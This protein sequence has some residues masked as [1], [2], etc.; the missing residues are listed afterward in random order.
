MRWIK[1][2]TINIV[3]LLFLLLFLE[4]LSAFIRLSS[5][6]NIKLPNFT[7][8]N[9]VVDFN[10]PYH[11]C[12]EMKT[13]VLLSHV[14]NTRNS[15]SP[16]KGKVINDYVSYGI[17]TKYEN[18]IL[19]LGGST[20][21]G[22]YQNISNGET[23]PKILSEYSKDKF[24]IL[25]GGVGAYS[26]L[27]ELY[28]FVRDG[29][30]INNLRYVIS[31]NGINELPDYQGQEI[32]RS[33]NY[34]FLSNY[35]VAMNES[36]VWID[37]RIS[38]TGKNFEIYVRNFLPN[39]MSLIDYLLIGSRSTNEKVSNLV[40]QAEGV[41]QNKTFKTIN[42][43]ERWESNVKRLNA[44]VKASGA[45]YIVFLQ[46]TLGIEGIQSLPMEN[47]NDSKIF[48]DIKNTEYITNIRNLYSELKKRCA[49]LEF[50]IDISNIAPPIGNV[51]TD[52]RHHNSKGN[53]EIAKKIWNELD[54]LQNKDR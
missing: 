7:G 4:C 15:C 32:E 51:Y 52:A 49:Y 1:I 2:I 36:Q 28:K 42:A 12:N 8:E 22:F 25:N 54:A 45:T 13:D 33:K 48:E 30:R 16:K 5:G 43:A 27:Q 29:P 53:L 40:K 9:G 19:T 37:Q 50:C 41:E 34:P 10:S 20:T 18:V 17:N 31:L 14:P 35:Q 44:L 11:P 46:P 39:I 3:V 6:K 47:S 38:L 21:S 24:T 23:W 26:S